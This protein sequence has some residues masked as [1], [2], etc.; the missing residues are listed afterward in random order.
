MISLKDWAAR[1]NV[2]PEALDE[3]Q[4]LFTYPVDTP[5]SLQ[6]ASEGAVSNAVRLEASRKGV[7]LYRNNVG[8]CEDKRGRLVRYGWMNDSKQ[9]NERIKSGDLIGIRPVLITQDMVG[10]TIGQFVMR[11]V[12]KGGWMFKG[13]P[14]E[15][16]QLACLEFVVSLGGDACFCNDIG[17]I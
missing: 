7:R 8:A 5:T 13:D 11:E 16:A 12:K 15:K 10:S 17:S 1:H 14:H 4:K 6:G 2:T 3:L 9:M